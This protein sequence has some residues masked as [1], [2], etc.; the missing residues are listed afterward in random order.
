MTGVKDYLSG[1]VGFSLADLPY[2]VRRDQNDAYAEHDVLGS[3]D[4]K[5]IAKVLG[6]VMKQESHA[7]VFHSALQFLL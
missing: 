6:Y 3:S 2:N 5:N 1:K 7:H 4:T